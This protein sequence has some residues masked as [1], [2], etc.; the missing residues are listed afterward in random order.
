MKYSRIQLGELMEEIYIDMFPFVE[1]R[2][3]GWSSRWWTIC[4]S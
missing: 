4:P 2:G 1:M 3:S